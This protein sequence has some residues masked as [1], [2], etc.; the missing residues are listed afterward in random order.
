MLDH[1][2]RLGSFLNVGV[3]AI[4]LKYFIFSIQDKDIIMVQ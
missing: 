1:F 4:E 2:Q 3:C